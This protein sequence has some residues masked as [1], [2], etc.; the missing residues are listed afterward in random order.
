VSASGIRDVKEHGI[1][2]LSASLTDHAAIYICIA[3]QLAPAYCHQELLLLLL[4]Q[5]CLELL[6]S[7]LCAGGL[8]CRCFLSSN[9]DN[10]PAAQ[11]LLGASYGAAAAEG[12]HLRPVGLLTAHTCTASHN[13][14]PLRRP[15]SSRL[16]VCGV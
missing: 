12:T 14:R 3:A 10:W 15:D 13:C 1:D 9:G 16:H 4:L 8:C 2:A 7:Y 5:G 6:G 11:L